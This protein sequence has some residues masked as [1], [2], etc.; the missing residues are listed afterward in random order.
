M[1]LAAQRLDLLA[2]G[3]FEIREV[4]HAHAVRVPALMAVHV[5]AEE[6]NQGR[7]VIPG[8]AGLGRS[9]ENEDLPMAYGAVHVRHVLFPKVDSGRA[10]CLDCLEEDRLEVV[11][12]GWVWAV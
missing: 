1:L 8:V 9:S 5:A 4:V 11:P 12:S 10:T 7:C 6:D 3:A 2:I